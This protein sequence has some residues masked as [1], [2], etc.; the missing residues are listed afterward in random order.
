MLFRSAQL[1]DMLYSAAMERP[2]ADVGHLLDFTNKAIELLDILEWQQ[3]EEILPLVL[4]QLVNSRGGEEQGQWRHP[5]DLLTPINQAS[6][7]LPEL[8]RQG[9]GKTWDDTKSI[10]QALLS[11]YPLVTMSALREAITQGAKPSQLSKALACAAAS[12]VARF[13]SANEL[14]DWITVLHT[15]SYCNA[16]DQAV[17]RCPTA[18]VTRGI[19]HGA[20]SI[21]FDRF[22]NVPPAKLPGERPTDELHLESSDPSEL[23]ENFLIALDGQHEG[24]S[25]A[26]AVARYLSL[27]HD[28][29]PMFDAMTYAAVRED[30]DFHTMQMVEAGIKVYLAWAN[31]PEG[32]EILI[33]VARYLAAH[34]PTPRARLQ[35]AN[36]ALRLHRGD[37][38]AEGD[39]EE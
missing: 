30:A 12:R 26:R 39:G 38:L 18:E 34:S 29:T 16:V 14:G 3:P 17:Q 25:A 5:I 1:C 6:A 4:N 33:G 23:I 37:N 11:D 10:K 22:L 21:Y 20:A 31:E 28:I 13:G 35:T 32:D 7:D 9:Y 24:Q 27:G 36:I 15:F 19:F 2:Y 8:L